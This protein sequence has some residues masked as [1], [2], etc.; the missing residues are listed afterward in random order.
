VSDREPCDRAF[1]VT[2]TAGVDLVDSPVFAGSVYEEGEGPLSAEQMA[3]VSGLLKAAPEIPWA[4]ATAGLQLL[5]LDLMRFNRIE[6]FS[7]G[8]RATLS[9]G[10]GELR[11]E[12]RAGTTG[13]VGARMEAGHNTGSALI[14]AAA[15]RGLEA[16]EIASQPFAVTS[17]ASAFLLGRDENDYFRGTGVELRLAP[18]SVRQQSWELRLFAEQ[19]RS[20]TGRADHSLR[21]LLDNGFDLRANILADPIDQAGLMLGVRGAHGD[22]PGS[23][24]TRAALDLHGEIGDRRFAMALLRVGADRVLGGGV[25]AAATLTGGISGGNLPIQRLWQIGGATTVRGH[26]PATLRGE[27]LWLAR[28]EL[29][30][31]GPMLRWSIFGDAGWAGARGDLSDADPILGA[32]VGVSLLDNLLRIDLARGN[33]GGGYRLYLRLGGGL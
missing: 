12:V 6:G 8:S 5:P 20:V 18:A 2:R 28:A 30:R 29:T 3:A 16:V 25:G 24:R 32:G 14:E 21:G 23:I 9:L 22:D 15:Y 33:G 19:Q 27:S 13:E 31:G 10:R 11:G 4:P 1:L 7:A 26:D 17:S